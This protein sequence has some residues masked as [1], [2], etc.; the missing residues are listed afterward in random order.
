MTI[1]FPMAGLSSRFNKAGYT[2]PKYMLNLQEK[3]VF[4]WVLEGFKTYFKTN[5][6]LFIYRNINH[7]KE[8]I[9]QECQ[10]LN[11]KNYQSVELDSPTL[12]QAHTVA[13][14]LEKIGIKDSILIFNIDTLRP[15]FHLPQNLDLDKIDG[16]LE[17]FKSEGEQWSFI[18]ASDEKL[19]KVA[20]TAEKTRISSFCSSGLYYFR[21]SEEF[22]SIFKTMQ[23]KNNLEKGEFYIAPMY[24]ELI[25]RNADIRYELIALNQ[26]LFCGT[27]REYEALKKLNL[28][29]KFL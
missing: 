18:K 15:N 4:F 28:S 20:K 2:L 16:Y 5:D 21:K 19:C 25:K 26:I 13:L 3:S 11:L 27:P 17:V 6:F 12:G 24:N 7:T 23:E 14:G 22:L 29:Q 10:K 9:K 1:I 8:F